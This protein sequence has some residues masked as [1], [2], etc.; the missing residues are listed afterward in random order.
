MPQVTLRSFDGSPSGRAL[1]FHLKAGL[2][3]AVCAVLCLSLQRPVFADH[4]PPSAIANG[5]AEHVLGGIS[6]HRDAVA[7][8][9]VRMGSPEKF[10]ESTSRD[11]PS[12]SGERSYEWNRNEIRLRMGTEFYTDKKA[13]TLVESPPIVVDVWGQHGGAKEGMTGRGLSIGDDLAKIKKLYGDRYQTDPHSVTIQWKDETTL[14]IDFSNDGH[15][16]H[17]RLFASQE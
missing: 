17:M 8:V 6:I 3:A 2:I 12:G 5:N 11:Y 15:I 9:I 16:T 14:S 4:F 7:S 13:M 10:E 1:K